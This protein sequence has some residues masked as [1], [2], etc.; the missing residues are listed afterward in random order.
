MI[1]DDEHVGCPWCAARNARTAVWCRSCG[2]AVTMEA[3]LDR[4]ARAD[5]VWESVGR[6]AP[7]WSA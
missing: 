5:E 1:L 4:V 7:T 2:G 3:H 6:P